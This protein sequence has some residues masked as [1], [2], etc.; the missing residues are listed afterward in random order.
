MIETALAHRCFTHQIS[1][2]QSASYDNVSESNDQL[3]NP[4]APSFISQPNQRRIIKRG[5]V[6]VDEIFPISATQNAF[7]IESPYFT[8]SQ[9]KPV[10]CEENLLSG[11]SSNHNPCYRGPVTCGLS[12]ELG[13]A[14]IIQAFLDNVRMQTTP[15]KREF[16]GM[17]NGIQNRK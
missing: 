9:I 10:L 16:N 14:C 8:P 7:S 13:Y 12:S 3:Y 5:H 11:A 4:L 6:V 17:H 2:Q 15:V 1:H